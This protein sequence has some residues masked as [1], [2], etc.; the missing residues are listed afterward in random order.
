[1]NIQSRILVVDDVIDVGESIAQLLD[2][3][4]Y[5]CFQAT[6]SL[7]ALE[8]IARETINLL[9]SDIRMPGMDGIGLAEKTKEISPHTI[10]MLISGGGTHFYAGKELELHHMVKEIDSVS[11]TLKKPIHPDVFIETIQSILIPAPK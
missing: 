7:D 11:Y 9:I 6:N 5:I 1:M 2:Q 8:I 10:I 3:E 4:G